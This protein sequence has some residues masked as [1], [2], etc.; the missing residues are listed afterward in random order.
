MAS[1][2]QLLWMLATC[3]ALTTLVTAIPL[4]QFYPYGAENGDNLIHRNDDGSSPP[5]PLPSQFNFF[6]QSVYDFYVSYI[7]PCQYCFLNTFPYPCV[8]VVAV[9][10]HTNYQRKVSLACI[11]ERIFAHTY[12]NYSCTREQKN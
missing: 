11:R 2:G 6:G 8:Y 12:R 5:I 10:D 3:I 4:Q 9:R 7:R 1:R